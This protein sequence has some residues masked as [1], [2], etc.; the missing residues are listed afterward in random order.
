MDILQQNVDGHC[1]DIMDVSMDSDV[2]WV[3]YTRVLFLEL[4][5]IEKHYT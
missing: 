4:D 2:I 3:M 5:V 1:M